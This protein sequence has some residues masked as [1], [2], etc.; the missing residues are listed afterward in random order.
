MATVSAPETRVQSTTAFVGTQRHHGP[1]LEASGMQRSPNRS[2][3]RPREA[4]R[5]AVAVGVGR[6]W[7]GSRR[8]FLEGVEEPVAVGVVVRTELEEAGRNRRPVRGAG[9]DD[10]RVD[11][12]AV[13]RRKDD[14]RRDGAGRVVHVLRRFDVPRER[15]GGHGERNR[16]RR[17]GVRGEERPSRIQEVR[18][19]VEVEDRFRERFVRRPRGGEEEV[20][21]GVGEGGEA[22]VR[23]GAGGPASDE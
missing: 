6:S 2:P 7:V 3:L 22:E 16:V 17:G 9:P 15:G 12:D 20:R 10:V 23:R 14:V 21:F 8:E 13:E 1:A 4:V 18:R 19:T 11:G 5:D